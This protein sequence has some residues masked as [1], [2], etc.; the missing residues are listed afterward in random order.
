MYL[1]QNQSKQIDLDLSSLINLLNK[2]KGFAKKSS[3]SL[4][5]RPNNDGLPKEGFHGLVHEWMAFDEIK[6]E[7]WQ[8]SGIV[9]ALAGSGVW[10]LRTLHGQPIGVE[11]TLLFKTAFEC[12]GDVLKREG[13]HS[14]AT[15]TV[16]GG[17]EGAVN[18]LG[19]Y[20]AVFTRHQLRRRFCNKVRTM[21]FFSF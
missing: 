3:N 20:A 16:H 8:G 7:I 14:R 21:M 18:Q 1:D 10:H 4:E 9:G 19:V 5:A 15:Y 11:R 17:R 2:K 12:V 13:A 6:G